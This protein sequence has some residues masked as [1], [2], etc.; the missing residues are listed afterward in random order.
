M[1]GPGNLS[2]KLFDM[3]DPKNE[4]LMDGDQLL[5]LNE[6]NDAFKKMNDLESKW[7]APIAK[8]LKEILANI[9]WEEPGLEFSEDM[10]ESANNLRNK[11]HNELLF[12]N[13]QSDDFVFKDVMP[14][15]MISLK[16]TSK[17]LNNHHRRKEEKQ[18]EKNDKK[19]NNN[20]I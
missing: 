12:K 6:I 13:I 1:E 7:I 2:S 19:N 10:M 9:D 4:Q 5:D 18:V 14:M 11:L 15:H 16:H 3:T 20:K 17:F 8:P